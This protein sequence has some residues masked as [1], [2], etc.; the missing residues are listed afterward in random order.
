MVSLDATFHG[1][2]DD[3]QLVDRTVEER[4]PNCGTSPIAAYCAAC[5]E[6]QPSHADY[7]ARAVALEVGS[8]FLS[9]DG[10]F[11][12]SIVALLSKPGLLTREYFSRRRSRYM[13]PFSLRQFPARSQ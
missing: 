12:R 1:P 11:W 10:R 13:R 3:V 7:S 4:C 5:G 2:S 6:R 9:L 8:E